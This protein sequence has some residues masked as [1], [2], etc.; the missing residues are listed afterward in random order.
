[1]VFEFSLPC[2]AAAPQPKITRSIVP[3][4]SADSFMSNGCSDRFLIS[5][6]TPR[7]S[8]RFVKTVDAPGRSKV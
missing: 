6:S 5:L 1:M 7:L 4:S 8:D 3:R 2:P